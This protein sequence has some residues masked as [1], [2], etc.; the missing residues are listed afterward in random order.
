MGRVVLLADFTPF[1]TPRP[2]IARPKII[3]SIGPGNTITSNEYPIALRAGIIKMTPLAASSPATIY[4]LIF[5]DAAKAANA[6]TI[7]I[8]LS[9]GVGPTFVISATFPAALMKHN[10]SVAAASPTAN[11]NFGFVTVYFRLTLY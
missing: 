11:A 2:S 9:T 8:R 10:A 3:P 1:N 5:Q 7:A 4:D 6:S